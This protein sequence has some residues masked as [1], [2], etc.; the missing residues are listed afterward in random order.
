MPSFDATELIAAHW[1]SYS[2]LVFEDHAH[3][4]FSDFSWIPV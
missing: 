2:R 3:G 1:E 4:P